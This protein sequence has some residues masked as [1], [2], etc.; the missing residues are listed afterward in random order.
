MSRLYIILS[1]ILILATGAYRLLTRR[2]RLVEKDKFSIEFMTKLQ[3]YV[4]SRGKDGNT[5]GWLI[6]NSVKMQNHMG[7]L[8]VIDFKPP[9]A[10]YFIRNYQI[11]VNGIPELPQ[12]FAEDQFFTTISLANQYASML[13]ESII[14]Y[15]GVLDESL[16]NATKEL[17]NPFKMFREGVQ[18]ILSLPLY[19]LEWVGLGGNVIMNSSIGRFFIRFLTGIVS[20][21]TFVSAVVSLVVGWDGFV[22]ITQT[23]MHF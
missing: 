4:D 18:T 11:I 23:Y 16:N 17:R 14:R 8:G 5:Y 12:A 15:H 20:I 13:T 2:K 19:L 6:H 3:Q 7:Q 1:I 22:N 21:I 9:V 10:N